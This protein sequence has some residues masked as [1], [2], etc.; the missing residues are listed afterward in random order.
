EEKLKKTNLAIV[1]IGATEQHGHH[2]GVGADWIQAWNIA[3]RVG[4][5]TAALVLPVMPYGVSGH[6]KEFPG[7]ITLTPE[8][9][10][11]V[12]YEIIESLDRYGVDRVVFMNG[13]GGN[14]GAITGAVKEARENMGT[15]CA[16]V[17]WWDV[18]SSRSIHGHPAEEHAG[19]AETALMLASRPEAVRME[20][21]VL[22][23]TRQVDDELQLV[24]SG[25]GR[26]KGGLVRIPLSTV[27][28]S[29]TGSMTEA[30]PDDVPGTSDYSKITPEFAE[31][32]MEDVVAW[33]SDF[34]ERF[35]GLSLPPN[36]PK[37]E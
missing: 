14:L 13:H 33:M 9:L 34:V 32:L 3:R 12:V 16:I 27:D 7:T 6:H 22:T 26:F 11:E 19:Y 29:E 10:Q 18:L 1:P 28:V 4:E 2:L 35:E 15:L 31:T 20:R 21:A 24:R 5:R 25:L 8:T 17:Q 30:H 36:K 37:R 23:P